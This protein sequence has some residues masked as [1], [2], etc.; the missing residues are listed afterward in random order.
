VPISPPGKRILLCALDWGL[1]HA[2]R[3]SVLVRSWVAAGA[4]VTL[5]SNGR[6]LAFWKKEFPALSCRELPDYGISYAPG[7]FL[8]P[9]LL[10]SL[11]RIASVRSAE[12]RLVRSWAHEFDAIVSDNRF[13]CAFA[14]KPSIFLTHQLHLAAP[15]G[16]AWGEGIAERGMA[17][18]LEPFH[19]VWIPDHEDNGLSGKLGHP[20]STKPFPPIR[21][22]GPL[23]RFENLPV[24]SSPWQGPWDVLALVSGPEPARTR[25]EFVLR[26]QLEPLPGR[27]LVVQGLPHL[28]ATSEPSMDAG[29]HIVPHLPS[30]DLA[31][32]LRGAKRILTRGGYST[33]M[34][35]EALE[36]LD[37]RCLLIPTP[38]Q[39]E[40][41]YLAAHLK[42]IRGIPWRA[43]K[44]LSSRHIL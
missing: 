32:A 12:Y 40:Q 33:L 25:F 6:S 22:I 7:P 13:G 31:T 34:D 21:W 41:E 26:Q 15:A 36:R 37:S 17:L 28:P 5:A 38:G 27:H 8:L 1:G 20:K 43:E 29:L 23:S 11:P 2:A 16:L 42:E 35:L 14:D 30:K 44:D 10:A 3:S 18:L 24:A 19:E 9:R 4:S 39:T